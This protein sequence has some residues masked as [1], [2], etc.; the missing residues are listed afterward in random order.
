MTPV[1]ECG[2]S[3]AIHPP[4]DG[5][6]IE[7]ATMMTDDNEDEKNEVSIEEIAVD[8]EE[9]PRRAVSWAD[10][11]LPSTDSTQHPTA[12]TAAASNLPLGPKFHEEGSTEAAVIDENMLLST[13]TATT[14]TTTT[15]DEP[16]GA[17]VRQQPQDDENC[18]TLQESSKEHTGGTTATMVRDETVAA[19]VL[20][21]QG[22]A[23]KDLVEAEDE[24]ENLTVGSS[25]KMSDE[26]EGLASGD[27]RPGMTSCKITE[28]GVILSP[29]L[30][31]L[32][33]VSFDKEESDA[34]SS[35]ASQLL[36]LPIDSLHCVAS[37]LTPLEWSNYGQTCVVASK[38]CREIFRRVRMHGFRCATEVIT[39]WVSRSRLERLS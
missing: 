32:D 19:E 37:F 23:A 22:E 6:T 4:Q 27:S 24:T 30:S 28:E 33:N 21:A 14:T 16:A 18:T 8:D 10:D 5:E 3:A 1:V 39:A 20:A 12:S 25:C 13:T 15:N 11:T 35:A 36:S 9:I 38:V 34:A 2:G 7:Q 29:S 17:P 26:D 31:N